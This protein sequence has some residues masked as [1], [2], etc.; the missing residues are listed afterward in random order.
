MCRSGNVCAMKYT[1]GTFHEYF[2]ISSGSC[3]KLSRQ[4]HTQLLINVIRG[5][6]SEF[7]GI[8]IYIGFPGTNPT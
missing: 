7:L 6:C 3:A 5:E 8:T 2:V 4:L 1:T